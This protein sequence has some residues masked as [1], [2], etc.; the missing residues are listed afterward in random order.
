MPAPPRTEPAPP[1]DDRAFDAAFDAAG[2]GRPSAAALLAR[3]R[4]DLVRRE[5][6]LRA[7][8]VEPLARLLLSHAEREVADRASLYPRLRNAA[9][10]CRGWYR[11]A[12]PERAEGGRDIL[13]ALRRIDPELDRLLAEREAYLSEAR[14]GAAEVLD[15]AQLDALARSGAFELL[16]R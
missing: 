13:P 1:V 5:A 2:A 16:G 12:G 3:A 4:L 10:G 8:Q 6:G 7:G 11:S 14:R 15:S 9:A